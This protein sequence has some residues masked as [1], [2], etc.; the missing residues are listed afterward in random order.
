M[1]RVQACPIGVAA[2]EMTRALVDHMH[3][4]HKDCKSSCLTSPRQ[5]RPRR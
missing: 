1:P 3:A 2:A 4:F 5:K